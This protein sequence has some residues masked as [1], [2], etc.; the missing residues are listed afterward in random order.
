[1]KTT[2]LNPGVQWAWWLYFW[3]AAGQASNTLVTWS[4]VWDI[5]V[6]LYSQIAVWVGQPQERFCCFVIVNVNWRKDH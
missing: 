2:A 4:I 1:M 3:G 5:S 6:P